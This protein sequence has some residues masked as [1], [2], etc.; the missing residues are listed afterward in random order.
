[1][2]HHV[3]DV[4]LWLSPDWTIALLHLPVLGLLCLGYLAY[5][6][7]RPSAGL[8]LLPHRRV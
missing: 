7:T 1:M 6:Q 8:G 2:I 4:V 5:G 3:Q